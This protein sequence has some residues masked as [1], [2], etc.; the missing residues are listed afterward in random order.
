M[1][2]HWFYYYFRVNMSK[3][4]KKPLVLLFFLMTSIEC[5][6]RGPPNHLLQTSSPRGGPSTKRTLSPRTDREKRRVMR[7][8]NTTY[9]ACTRYKRTNY[10]YKHPVPH[11]TTSHNFHSS[12]GENAIGS[13][14][15]RK[16]IVEWS[17]NISG[18]TPHNG[19]TANSHSLLLSL[20]MVSMLDSGFKNSARKRINI[21]NM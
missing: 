20:A 13:G 14:A 3:C 1:K 9:T 19:N 16:A 8:V 12:I 10:F 15:Q 17:H 7:I 5:K 2:N 6:Q 4:I 11:N 21:L 18:T